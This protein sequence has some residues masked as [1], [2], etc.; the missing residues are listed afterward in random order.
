V[1]GWS[2][3]SG[4]FSIDFTL[5][6]LPFYARH[7]VLATGIA[8]AVL[9]IVGIYARC[10]KRGENHGRWAAFASLVFG[11]Y[12]FQ[13]LIPV[14]DESRHIIAATPALVVL[15]F[16]GLDWLLSSSR[17]PAVARL[18]PENKR[19]VMALLL[20][21]LSMPVFAMTRVKKDTAGFAAPAEWIIE[22]APASRVLVCS[23]AEGEGMFISEIAMRDERPGIT[24]ERGSK[25]LVDP[26]GRTWDGR[27]LK[28]RFDADG[29][30][31]YLSA[32]KIDFIVLDSAVPERRRAGYHDQLTR[33]IE[34]NPM[35]F[36]KVLESPVTRA[37]EPM[38]RPLR[39]F[40]IR[41]TK[42][43]ISQ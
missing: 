36:W 3:N 6:A 17:F 37:G 39:L 18:A 31:E 8:I 25:S 40:R 19:R 42:N 14:G 22:N 1:G 33:A 26:K 24:V 32:G 34:D 38:Y 15:A 16:A 28:E 4:G 27:N 29:L 7:L 5:K 11:V 35:Q 12:V 23:D 21:F 43:P 2:D 20:V 41:G 30:V 10:V 9:A 13:C